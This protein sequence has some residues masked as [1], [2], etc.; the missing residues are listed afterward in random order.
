MRCRFSF[1]LRLSFAAASLFIFDD[2]PPLPPCFRFHAHARFC[3]DALPP[4]A[5]MPIALRPA[6]FSADAR[7]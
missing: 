4:D 7:L 5:A 2:W 6:V 1:H 3:R